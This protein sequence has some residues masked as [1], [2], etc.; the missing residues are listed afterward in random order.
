MYF[1]LIPGTYVF[2]SLKKKKVTSVSATQAPDIYSQAH[3]S[4][5]DH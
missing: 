3:V 5:S 1:D 4:F 2:K